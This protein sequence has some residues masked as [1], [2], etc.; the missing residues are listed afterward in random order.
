[1]LFQDKSIKNVKKSLVTCEVRYNGSIAQYLLS[2]NRGVGNDHKE[3]KE[4]QRKYQEHL[5]KY[6]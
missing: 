6:L 3:L 1:M 4:F 2:Y 5:Y